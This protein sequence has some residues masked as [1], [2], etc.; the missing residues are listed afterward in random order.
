MIVHGAV[1]PLDPICAL[2]GLP[3]NDD[4][5][6]GTILVEDED[7]ERHMQQIH[8]ECMDMQELH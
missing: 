7:G 1:I 6:Y 8:Q 5:D 2:C 4:E 3:I